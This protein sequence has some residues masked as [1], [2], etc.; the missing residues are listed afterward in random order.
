[1]GSAGLSIIGRTVNLETLVDFDKLLRIAKVDIVKL[2]YLGGLSLLVSFADAVAA[3][4]FV[5]A[6]HIWEPWFSS[7]ETWSG[8]SLPFERVAWL[9]LH[10][11]PLNLL[12][13]DV[14]RQVGELFGKVLFVPKDLD[15]DQD[16]SVVKV[17]VLV[18]EARRCSEL[19]S[20]KWKD[21][22]FRIWVDEELEDWVPDCLVMEDDED[23][24]MDSPV[25]SSPVVD[26]VF[27]DETEDGGTR[28]TEGLE[29]F[30]K[31]LFND[32]VQTEVNIPMHMHAENLG[33]NPNVG[34]AAGPFRPDQNV[35]IP[36]NSVGP[37]GFVCG[38]GPSTCGLGSVNG[39]IKSKGMRKSSL[40]P[41]HRK[42][43]A[44]AGTPSSPGDHRPLKRSRRVCARE[45]GDG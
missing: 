34:E 3:K 13:A 33:N 11:I 23:L 17:G 36:F 26:E 24:E 27:S 41:K 10:G 38:S 22:S 4:W 9:K 35:D 6:R 44:Q 18:G 15:E 7:L 30:R 5:D 45:W 12:E 8:Q 25:A 42:G 20:L 43:K 37:S 19:V 16:L 32:G 21:K 14:L 2:Q 29:E 39:P 40:G 31:S 28:K 1:M